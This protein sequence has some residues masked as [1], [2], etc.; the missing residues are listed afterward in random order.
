M[1]SHPLLSTPLIGLLGQLWPQDRL[2]IGLRVCKWLHQHLLSHIREVILE[3]GCDVSWADENRILVDLARFQ[4]R[5]LSIIWGKPKRR[6]DQVAASLLSGIRTLVRSHVSVRLVRL[7][8]SGMGRGRQCLNLRAVMTILEHCSVLAELRLARWSITSSGDNELDTAFL[9]K[10]LQHCSSLVSLDLSGNGIWNDC[11][12]IL[13]ALRHCTALRSLN[14]AGNELSGL[15]HV[16]NVAE[17]APKLARFPLLTAL[18]LSGTQLDKE[19]FAKIARVLTDNCSRLIHLDLSRNLLTDSHNSSDNVWNAPDQDDPEE[20]A[21]PP[22]SLILERCRALVHLSLT[23][24]DSRVWAGGGREIIV[25]LAD[26]IGLY[27][28]LTKLGLDGGCD[29]FARDTASNR[30]L[31]RLLEALRQCSRITHL[32][33]SSFNLSSPRCALKLS[34]ALQC[35]PALKHLSLQRAGLTPRGTR[36]LLSGLRTCRFLQ[37]CVCVCSDNLR[38]DTVCL[39]LQAQT[40]RHLTRIV[41]C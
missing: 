1:L 32:S 17:W 21:S 26:W 9:V 38:R 24:A 41:S 28:S 25:S 40:S 12:H 20:L 18:D 35:M 22:L 39:L 6:T 36:H 31:L 19:D 5:E 11:D 37:L 33:L 7:D 34:A 14:L 23:R 13:E 29:G 15:D 3:V 2:V 30:L 10:G 8:L 16:D 27:G 4:G